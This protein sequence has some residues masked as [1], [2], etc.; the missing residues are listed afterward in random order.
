MSNA[1]TNFDI[2]ATSLTVLPNYF[3][4]STKLLF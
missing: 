2:P 1:A 3:D 4:G